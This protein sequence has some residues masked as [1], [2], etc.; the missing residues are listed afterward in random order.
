VPVGFIGDALGLYLGYDAG[1]T[2]TYDLSGTGAVS[3]AGSEIVGYSGTGNFNQTGGTNT[4]NG[5]TTQPSPGNLTAGAQSNGVGTYTLS[6]GSLSVEGTEV[7]GSSGTGNFSQ[8]GGTNTAGAL[9]IGA[10]A[11]STGTYALS[12][13]GA[14]SVPGGGL[15]NVGNSGT[16]NFN[17]TG[18]TNTAGYL[19]LGAST[20]STG[21]YT[22][23]G[24]GSLT[25]AY[26]AREYVGDSGVGTFVQTGGTNGTDIT[27]FLG[28]NAFSTGGYTLS[29]TGSLS[30]VEEYVGYNGT[31][32]FNQS[33]GTNVVAPTSPDGLFLGYSIGSTGTYTLS[34]TGT[35]TLSQNSGTIHE[36]VGYSGTGIFNQSGGLNSTPDLLVADKAG[37]TGTY[38]L[39]S[40][41]SLSVTNAE[42]IGGAGI[43]TFVQ[44]GGTNT[45]SAGRIFSIGGFGSTYTLTGGTLS[46]GGSETVGSGGTGYFNQSGG[47]NIINLGGGLTIGSGPGSTGAYTLSGTG[48]LTAPGAERLGS[49]SPTKGATGYFNQTGGTNTVGTELDLGEFAGSN[50]TYILSDGTLTAPKVYVGGFSSGSGGTGTLTIS[51][52][53][54]LSVAGT[55]TVFNT[56]TMNMNGGTASAAVLNLAG[57][58]TQMAGS[59]TFGQITGNG[60]VAISGGITTLSAGGGASQVSSLTLSGAGTLDITNN[61]LAINYGAAADPVATIRT[62]LKSAYNGG[63][64]TGPGLTSSTVAAQVAA[65]IAAHTGG[66]YGIGYVDGGIDLNQSNNAIVQATGNQIIYTPALIGDA[67]LD[68]SVTFI[69]LGIVA[70]NLGAINSDWEHGDFN[71]DGTTNFLD[72]GLLAQNLSKTTLNT[73]LDQMLPNPSAALTAQWN[74]AVA[75][76]ESNS[77]QPADLPEPGM[78]GLLTLSAA[79]LMTRRRRRI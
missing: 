51:N 35:L 62:Y 54:Q 23:S 26:A 43:G 13:T 48:S 10:N 1:S 15:E 38:T 77:T 3:T 67:N 24:T 28:Y 14:L 16:G 58:Y 31:G 73:P 7:I 4:I 45:I 56:G 70:Q 36:D 17:Q 52:T 8:T 21:T 20:G 9:T 60:P 76:L 65:T 46:A 33:G 44:A 25:L 2:G 47:T 68:G 32:N 59:A 53:G 61:T 22:L 42:F 5:P 34:G 37:S 63:I 12:G 78:I 79:G 30:A 19:I 69:D 40:T 39:S 50:G 74:L 75:E 11:G 27:L 55:L 18:G 57:S 71:Y 72:I 6:A 41:G 64:W 66:V 29:G 49:G